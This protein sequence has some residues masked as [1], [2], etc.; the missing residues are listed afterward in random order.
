MAT[1]NIMNRFTGAAIFT[2]TVSDSSQTQ[3]RDALN[4]AIAAGVDLSGANLSGQTIDGVQ[5]PVGGSLRK[6]DFRGSSVKGA[7]LRGADLIGAD[8]RGADFT[9]ADTTGATVDGSTDLRNATGIAL[10][11]NALLQQIALGQQIQ[12]NQASPDPEQGMSPA[13]LVGAIG[14]K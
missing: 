1:V 14:T 13:D 12:I 7:S 4:Q 5:F 2:A 8:L 11:P 6:V 9:G 3:F 10:E